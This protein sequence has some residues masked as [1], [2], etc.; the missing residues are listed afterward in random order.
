M[1]DKPV[2]SAVDPDESFASSTKKYVPAPVNKLFKFHVSELEKTVQV[3]NYKTDMNGNPNPDF[4]KAQPVLIFKAKLDS[5]TDADP[6]KDAKG[7]LYSSWITGFYDKDG[8]ERYTFGPKSKFGKIAEALTGSV[9]EFQ[10]LKASQIIGLPF[11]CALSAGTKDPN[12]QNLNI[13]KILGPADD[14]KR[15]E[16]AE[17]VDAILAEAGLA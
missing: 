2:F 17:E 7:Q 6:E 11:Q 13:D 10:A 1:Q 3:N 12:K 4:G 5:S 16:S 15:V 9:E 8:K 14:Q